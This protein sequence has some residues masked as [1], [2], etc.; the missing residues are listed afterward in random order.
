MPLGDRD[1]EQMWLLPPSLDDLL[2]F[3]HPSRFVGEFVDALDREGWKEL[4]VA[5]EGDPLGSPI[6]SSPGLFVC[7]A[8]WP[9]DGENS[10]RKLEGA[11]RDQIPYLWL[12]GWQHPDHN[13]LWRF[14]KDHRQAM[15]CLFKQSITGQTAC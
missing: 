10:R 8:V 14:Y 5:I 6:L 9:H 13:T 4:G 7:V 11:C 15:R 12:T 1:P 3:D 2:P